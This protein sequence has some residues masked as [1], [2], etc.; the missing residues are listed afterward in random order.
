[1]RGQVQRVVVQI[2]LGLLAMCLGLGCA[3]QGGRQAQ[4][5]AS[6]FL[7]AASADG[8]VGDS[9]VTPDADT[10]CVPVSATETVC[11]GVDDDCNG[12]IDDVD[13]GNDGI[14]DCLRIGVLGTPG[15]NPSANFQAYLEARG[16]TVTRLHDSAAPD[17]DL[18]TLQQFDVVLLDRLVRD[19]TAVEA[20][21]LADWVASGGGVMSMTGYT[22]QQPDWGRPNSLLATIGLGYLGNNLLNGPVTNFVAHP[23]TEGLTSVTFLGGFLVEETNPS[24]VNTVVATLGTGSAG[25]VQQRDLGRVF[26]WGDEWIEFDSE[27]SSLPEIQQLWVNI[28]AWL[29]PQNTCQLIVN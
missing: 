11:D 25:T 7:D 6:S 20:Q 23:I 1:M 9:Q 5:D 2:S 16:T 17:L 12:Q 14:C 24:G 26:V 27:W 8:T 4:V 10:S 15:V 28:L 3:S 13:L 29:G 18:A 19:Y 22:G 21:L